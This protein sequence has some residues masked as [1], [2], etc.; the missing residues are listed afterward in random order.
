MT[1]IEL[2]TRDL[3][4]SARACALQVAIDGPSGAGK[5][6]IGRELAR[7]LQIPV[8]DTGL[9]YRVV[10]KIT[11]DRGV[12]PADLDAVPALA[13][14]M[15]FTLD[16]SADS[17]RLIMNGKPID[18]ALL[19]THEVDLAV[20][21]IAEMGEVRRVLVQAQRDMAAKHAI[22]MLGRDIT[23]VVLPDAPVKLFITADV[24][25]RAQR[26]A[27]DRVAESARPGK[28]AVRAEIVARDRHDSGRSV[29]P[30]RQSP[31]AVVI[32][33]TNRSVE[34]SVAAATRVVATAL[35]GFDRSEETKHQT[36]RQRE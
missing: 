12:D 27:G 28:D 2:E 35:A 32:D 4:R 30:L 8:L 15:V 19:H 21:R 24:E 23:T 7:L 3:A 11:F 26:R 5:T 18:E 31:D 29:S 9:M 22:V 1:E 10:A 34:E 14:A 25:T 36:G 13:S 6:T 33:T 20:P 16:G 17:A